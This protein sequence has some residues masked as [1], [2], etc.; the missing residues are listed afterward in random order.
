MPSWH[1][2]H[3]TG[4][5]CPPDLSL[6]DRVACGS[7]QSAHSGAFSLPVRTRA[8]C[9]LS[10]YCLAAFLWQSRQV[11]SSS[12][13]WAR[14]LAMLLGSLLWLAASMSE[15]QPSQP[16]ELCT[17]SAKPF[18]G[19]TSE[20]FSPFASVFSRFGLAWHSRQALSSFDRPV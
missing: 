4:S 5:A 8:E 11:S 3:S 1:F 10:S 6:A 20:S 17:D 2:W 18:A 19:I 15:W 16:L 9:T 13:E 14:L 12:S 7:W